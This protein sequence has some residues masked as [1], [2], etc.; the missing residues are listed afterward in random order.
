MPDYLTTS[1]M[2]KRL[3]VKVETVRR[4]L[5]THK[6]QGLSFGHKGLSI[7]LR[8]VTE[9]K[10]A[11][12]DREFLATVNEH[13]RLNQNTDTLI[14][15]VAHMTGEYLHATRCYVAEIS[16][17]DGHW[18]I[19]R[20]D[21]LISSSLTGTYPLA[22]DDPQVQFITTKGQTL[23]IEDTQTHPLTAQHYASRYEPFALRAYITVPY[24]CQD[25]SVATLS[26]TSNV[27]RH[28]QLREIRVLETTAFRMWESIERLRHEQAL[29]ESEERFR[30][31]ANNISQLAWIADGSG[32][33]FWYNQRW[34]DYTGTTLQE[35]EGWG[36][37]KVH[38]PDHVR[39]VVEK[40]SHCFATGEIWEDT[41]PL[42]GKD[43]KY[44]WFLSRAI[45]MHDEQGN[46]VRWLGTNTDVTEQKQLEQQKDEFLG[47]ASHEL[48]TPLTS[49][50]GYAQ[51][52]ES[53]FRKS[54][55]TASATLMQRM[56]IQINKLQH[57]VED[58][59]DITRLESGKLPLRPTMFDYN[60]LVSEVV[61]EIRRTATK[62]HV[63]LEVADAITLTADRDRIGQ[64]LINLLTNAIKYSPRANT[65]IVKVQHSKDAVITS[66]QDFGIGIAK[67]RQAHLFERFF[68]VE[69]ESQQIYPGLGLGLYISAE[70][71]KRHQGQIWVESE[72]DKGTTVSFS[73][74]QSW[75]SSEHDY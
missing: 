4:W 5:R 44:C 33:I 75:L 11:E 61:V 47:I 1:Q 49:L 20:T 60:E 16:E 56:E 24:H 40:V 26:V 8:D 68:R 15:K 52:L 29:R 10:Y 36:W 50:K 64:V 9:K 21:Y 73:L 31:L 46:I 54:G 58:L 2:A 18:I 69:G 51:V 35:M 32:W 43:G 19:K 55:D 66:V 28:W 34:F 53:R 48:K 74:P 72:L 23:A 27:A 67:E 65:I 22:D 7:F 57:L 6:L 62:H 14:A 12:Q 41:F 42:R 25:H 17:V 37:Q 45:P 70:F 39:R 71:I 13:I 59:L 38:H 30:T 63:V 3:G